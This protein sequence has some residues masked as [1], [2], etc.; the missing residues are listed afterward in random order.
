MSTASSKKAYPFKIMD[1]FL[2]SDF[3]ELSQ[4]NSAANMVLGHRN[5]SG[6][7]PA[8]FYRHSMIEKVPV[9]I[10]FC[11]GYHIQFSPPIQANR[12]MRH[13]DYILSHA[14][15]HNGMLYFSM[16][17]DEAEKYFIDPDT[18][19]SA[20]AKMSVS[21]TSQETGSFGTFSLFSGYSMNDAGILLV[22]S[23]FMKILYAFDYM[24]EPAP[25]DEV[26]NILAKED[27]KSGGRFGFSVE[28]LIRNLVSRIQ[29][30]KYAIQ[31][32]AHAFEKMGIIYSVGDEAALR[33]M[34][35][36]SREGRLGLYDKLLS[37]GIQYHPEKGTITMTSKYRPAQPPEFYIDN[38]EKITA[39]TSTITE[40]T[41]EVSEGRRSDKSGSEGILDFSALEFD[42]EFRNILEKYADFTNTSASLYFTKFKNVYHGLQRKRALS[43]K[44]KDPYRC[45]DNFMKKEKETAEGS[46][47]KGKAENIAYTDKMRDIVQAYGVNE[48]TAKKEFEKFKAYHVRV[49]NERNNW[50]A[51]WDGW[52]M[53]SIERTKDDASWKLRG[54]LE[55]KH[56]LA[57]LIDGAI[58][59]MLHR[60]GV[61]PSDVLSGKR[62]LTEILVQK[63]PVPP[64]LGKERTETLM[65]FADEEVQ[66]KAI[67]EILKNPMTD[68]ESDNDKE[69]I[70]VDLLD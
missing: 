9:L 43:A 35:K 64:S 17:K 50:V 25:L 5:I 49:G 46:T 52:L 40:N 34:L 12:E 19:F 36:K 70:E 11:G 18:Y 42:T 58:R 54:V 56:H 65:S 47:N 28:P 51:A 24:I 1:F 61:D 21:F 6:K 22:F 37:L 48:D 55:D 39:N 14:K 32:H 23:D 26:F 13:F 20:F 44:Y 67:A 41:K 7:V 63:V 62:Q 33:N 60:V 30:S 8:F 2:N 15:F 45:F 16:S 68:F 10:D 53:R 4:G 31:I 69:I 27:K 66:K 59:R 57:R 29:R 3:G 38:I